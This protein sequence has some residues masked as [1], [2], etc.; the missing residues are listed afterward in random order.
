MRVLS[1]LENVLKRKK[2]EE[3]LMMQ[4]TCSQ[5]LKINSPERMRGRRMREMPTR[6]LL[7]LLPIQ[8][9]MNNLLYKIKT[10]QARKRE[11]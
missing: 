10:L 5:R 6:L 7:Y 1:K 11:N 8:R 3:K 2:D 9:P 4:G